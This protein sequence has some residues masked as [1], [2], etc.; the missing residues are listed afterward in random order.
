MVTLEITHPTATKNGLT[1]LETFQRSLSSAGFT[2]NLHDTFY[3]LASLAMFPKLVLNPS[4]LKLNDQNIIDQLGW[5][6]LYVID[7]NGQD[8]TLVAQEIRNSLGFETNNPN[9]RVHVPKTLAENEI[10]LYACKTP[11]AP[12]KLFNYIKSQFTMADL[13]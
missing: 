4:F 13:K 1:N 6:G 7:V 9:T 8:I 5:L 12:E 11:Q 3:P 2:T 10:V